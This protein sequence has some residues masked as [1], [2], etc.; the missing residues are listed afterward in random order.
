MPAKAALNINA[1]LKAQTFKARTW[2]PEMKKSSKQNEHCTLINKKKPA[3]HTIC[4]HKLL[5]FTK[6]HFCH[7]PS[8]SRFPLFQKQGKT[9]SFLPLFPRTFPSAQQT[10]APLSLLRR[11]LSFIPL[12]T[13][14]YRRPD[15]G[16]IVALQT[17]RMANI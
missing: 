9:G 8:V 15:T 13:H 5:G 2:R 17:G 6:L 16:V 11:N 7:T 4:F 10:R 14:L 12:V 1:L 3:L